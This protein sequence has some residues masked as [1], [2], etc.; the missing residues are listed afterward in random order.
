[1]QRVSRFTSL[2]TELTQGTG[3]IQL[4]PKLTGIQIRYCP[5]AHTGARH[6]V[7]SVL[8]RLYYA[9]PGVAYRVTRLKEGEPVM[10]LEYGDK[11]KTVSLVGKHTDTIVHELTE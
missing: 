5:R 6:F 10:V 4:P 2:V 7:K 3:A 8:P 11:T 1:M 9:N